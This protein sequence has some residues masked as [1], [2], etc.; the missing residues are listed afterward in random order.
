MHLEIEVD[1]HYAAKQPGA[2]L[3][4]IVPS[5][6]AD[7]TCLRSDLHVTHGTLQSRV[8][9]DQKIGYRQWLRAESDFACTYRGCVAIHRDPVVF[10]K[11]AA[12]EFAD[13]PA[14][15]VPYLMPSRFCHSEQFSA[16]VQSEFQGAPSGALVAEMCAWID[17]KPRYD[18]AASLPGATATD[19]FHALAGVCRDYAHLLIT[20]ARAIGVPARFASV[21]GPEVK[22]QDFHSIAEVWLGDAWH[23]IDPTGMSEPRSVVRIGVGRDAADVA[24]LTSYM[25]LNFVAQCVQVTVGQR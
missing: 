13:I 25:P 3:L 18:P 7:Q 17:R 21:Y 15:V 16:F 14:E 22:P 23:M 24:F 19:I 9:A 5:S 8:F 11:L 4:Q 2:I 12:Q 1:L 6:G 20:F 10:S